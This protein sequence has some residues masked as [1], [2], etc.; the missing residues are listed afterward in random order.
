VLV[1][2]EDANQDSIPRGNRIYTRMLAAL[3]NEMR[4]L[5]FTIYDESSVGMETR[6]RVHRTDAELI[7]LAQRVPQPPVDAVVAVEVYGSAQQD[8]NS[9]VIRPNIRIAGRVIQV[10]T[11]KPLDNFEV[12][13][14][15]LPPVP[16][17]CDRDCILDNM[18]EAAQ[19]IAP[20]V[21]NALASQLDA[22]FP[23]GAKAGA[24]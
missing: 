13:D 5:G 4:K 12:V 14:K 1:V 8:P 7:S 21:A 11:G 2:G 15:G 18:G 24:R 23:P 20:T 10:Q 22:R 3:T 6:A 9:H 19:L 16:L 17:G